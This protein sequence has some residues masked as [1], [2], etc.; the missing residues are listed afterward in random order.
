[1]NWLRNKK[2][3]GFGAFGL[4]VVGVGHTLPWND[5]LAAF[6]SWLLP[7]GPWA[8]PMFVVVYAA[9]T[10]LCLPN[11]LLILIGGTLFGL[12]KGIISVSIAD[13]LS[14]VL[15]YGIGRTIA[16][17]RIKRWMQTNTTLAQLDQA[18][19]RKGW[20]IVL[21]TRLSPLVPSNLLNYGFSCTTINFWQYCLFTWLGML[22]VISLY[23]YLGAF[24]M[25]MMSRDMS[26][27]HLFLRGLGLLVTIATVFY[28]THFAR[29]ALSQNSAS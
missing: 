29:R 27:G 11:V 16:R 14:A 28:T 8:I 3:W 15:C 9:A 24:G 1:M 4:L 19:G 10:V 23:V 2:V 26:P 12:V 5:W 6:K 21:L 7:L 20:K 17:Q 13:T 18:V 25:Q 22:P